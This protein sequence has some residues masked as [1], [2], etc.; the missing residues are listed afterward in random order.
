MDHGKIYCVATYN[1]D[2]VH[3]PHVDKDIVEDDNRLQDYF[4]EKKIGEGQHSVVKLATKE[5]NKYAIKMISKDR[6]RSVDGLLRLEKEI[7]A[8]VSL[9]QHPN[10]VNFKEAIH[11]ERFLYLVMEHMPMDMFTFMDN[12]KAG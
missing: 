7:N 3:L 6:I 4:F 9:S 10:I 2:F 8:L 12:F 5:R 11:A 1:S